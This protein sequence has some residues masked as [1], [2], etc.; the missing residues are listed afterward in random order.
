MR[1]T[2]PCRNC[3]RSMRRFE[4]HARAARRLLVACASAPRLPQRRAGARSSRRRASCP[5]PGRSL[6]GPGAWRGSRA[7]TTAVLD[8]WVRSAAAAR[9]ACSASPAP[10]VSGC[11]RRG[12]GVGRGARA[13]AARDRPPRQ[14]APH[15]SPTLARSARRSRPPRRSRRAAARGRGRPSSVTRGCES[16]EIRVVAR[17]DDEPDRG[18]VDRSAS[19]ACELRLRSPL[20]LARRPAARSGSP[21]PAFASTAG[22]VVDG[23]GRRARRRAWRGSLQ[24]HDA[25]L[26]RR[27]PA[28]RARAAR[29][30][31]LRAGHRARDRPH[32]RETVTRARPS[33]SSR[34]PAGSAPRRAAR[35]SRGSR[36]TRRTRPRRSCPPARRSTATA[37][38]RRRS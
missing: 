28:R 8:L 21:A 27:R 3:R 5:R 37:S 19:A 4:P 22:A 20:R 32:R 25:A 34:P 24:P 38:P 1:S 2:H 10:T 30:A 26:R 29:G 17:P 35:R 12:D 11:A 23:P 14:D 13:R 18:P 36:R 6:A 7:A 33:F 9:A 16:A 31:A 15:G